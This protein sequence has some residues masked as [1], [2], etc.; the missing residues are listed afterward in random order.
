[1]DKRIVIP[2]IFLALVSLALFFSYKPEKEIDLGAIPTINFKNKDI[3]FS[4]TDDN[5]GENLII[6]TEKDTYAGS[7]TAYFS[8]TNT[9][10]SQNVLLAGLFPDSNVEYTI[11]ELKP[12][13]AFQEN[14]YECEAGTKIVQDKETGEG[15]NQCLADLVEKQKTIYKDVSEEL[16]KENTKSESFT[17]NLIKPI[18][19]GTD[20]KGFH[21]TYI[22]S[23]ETKYFTISFHL[24]IEFGSS[25]PLK[26]WF[27]EA[28][29]DMGGIGQI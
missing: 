21:R 27:I 16:I 3:T 28:Y 22:N 1:M 20:P 12:Q 25:S 2:V 7:D 6:R 17:S 19:V 24:P 13:Q 8:V 23:G 11:S 4:Y 18:P 10:V 14:Y 29:G 26:E 5:T 15:I 9:G